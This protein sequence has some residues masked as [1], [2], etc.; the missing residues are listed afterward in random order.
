MN[1]SHKEQVER[2]LAIL[3]GEIKLEGRPLPR[4]SLEEWQAL[5]RPLTRSYVTFVPHKSKPSIN[6]HVS[7]QFNDEQL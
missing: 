7:K 6:C 5:G 3:R 2:G 1:T 4:M